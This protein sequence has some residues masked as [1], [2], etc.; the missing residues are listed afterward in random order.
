MVTESLTKLIV[1][2]RPQIYDGEGNALFDNLSVLRDLADANESSPRSY[3]I[4]STFLNF[5]L[6]GIDQLLSDGDIIE[7]MLSADEL[8][9][10]V[11]GF[12]HSQEN[13]A[14]EPVSNSLSSDM[15]K[16]EEYMNPDTES[17]STYGIRYIRGLAAGIK[18][19]LNPLNEQSEIEHF[20]SL[21]QVRS[22]NRMKKL[23]TVRNE[24]LKF[25]LSAEI[26]HYSKSDTKSHFVSL[27]IEEIKAG[28]GNPMRSNENL[29][30]HMLKLQRTLEDN[31][32]KEQLVHKLVG[33]IH[34]FPT[35]RLVYLPPF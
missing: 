26:E 27:T 23:G 8:G 10:F 21:K 7:A 28:S 20:Y 6:D 13:P 3:R 9:G 25:L 4:F 34:L 11:K 35:Y 2:I 32:Y 16:L 1:G 24:I 19:G 15:Q 12:E 18:L 30:Y 5:R 29:T 17:I 22:N 31:P 14:I 33:E